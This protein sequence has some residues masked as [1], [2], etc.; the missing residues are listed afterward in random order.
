[1]KRLKILVSL[2][3]MFAVFSFVNASAVEKSANFS[4]ENEYDGC[5]FTINELACRSAA[6]GK[7]DK[8][9]YLFNSSAEKMLVYWLRR[10]K[11]VPNTWCCKSSLI[12]KNCII[13]LVY[14]DF[15]AK[16][17]FF[18]GLQKTILHSQIIPIFA[19]INQQKQT[20]ISDK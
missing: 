19:P 6:F 15:F 5:V 3:G 10:H 16:I 8:L 20:P 2:V 7:C 17:H 18:I 11:N 1:M 14:F 12:F 4:T 13:H 9:F